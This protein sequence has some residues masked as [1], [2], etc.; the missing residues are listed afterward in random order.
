MKKT[1][2]LAAV[3]RHEPL[4]KKSYRSTILV[5]LTEILANSVEEAKID[6]IRDLPKDIPSDQVEVIIRPF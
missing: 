5:P 4:D 1:L 2:Y 3:V 6:L